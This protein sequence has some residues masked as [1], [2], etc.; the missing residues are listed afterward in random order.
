MEITLLKRFLW[1]LCCLAHF[2]S[3]AQVAFPTKSD[4]RYY[5]KIVALGDTLR[6]FKAVQDRAIAEDSSFMVASDTVPRYLSKPAFNKFFDEYFTLLNYQRQSFAE[7]NSASAEVSDNSTRVNLT[8]SKKVRTSI[9]SLGTVLNI[10]DNTGTLFSGDKPTTGTQINAGYSV[11]LKNRRSNFFYNVGEQR[12]NYRAR[13]ETLDSLE[14][15]YRENNPSLYLVLIDKL[16][17]ANAGKET[18]SDSIQRY[19]QILPRARTQAQRGEIDKKIRQWRNALVAARA[20]V[21]KITAELKKLQFDQPLAEFANG[22]QKRTID[23]MIKKELRHE[24][25]TQFSLHWLSFGSSYKRE[26]Y[27]TYDSTLTFTKR[28]DSRSFNTWTFSATYNYY[29]SKTPYNKK[30][31]KLALF[32]HSVYGGFSYSVTTSNNYS[33]LEEANISIQTIKTNKDSLYVFS[34]DKKLR[35]ITTRSFETYLVHRWGAQFTGMFGR[36]EFVGVN[37]ITSLDREKSLTTYNLRSGLLFRFKNSDDTK[38]KVNFEIFLNLKDLNNNKDSD[39]NAW[40]RKQIGI[41]TVIPFD[42]VFFK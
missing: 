8:L 31:N 7:G 30:K 33:G 11:L 35:N 24:G 29:R 15:L 19:E 2:P 6:I 41:A 32:F 21:A 39:K 12:V 17:Q 10:K 37:V 13:K 38:P 34:T 36:E 42:K 28:V 18:A 22:I 27:D 20:E 3:L 9:I 4:S 26:L 5:E 40:Q 1:I 23:Q 14:L 16:N 25:I